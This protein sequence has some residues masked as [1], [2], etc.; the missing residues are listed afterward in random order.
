MTRES[1]VAELLELEFQPP[2]TAPACGFGLAAAG[3]VPCASAYTWGGE[4]TLCSHPHLRPQIP[5]GVRTSLASQVTGLT[6]ALSGKVFTLDPLLQR[7]LRWERPRSDAQAE[8]G[9][10]GHTHINTC[11]NTCAHRAT[12]RLQAV[13]PGD[14][15][16][17]DLAGCG[18]WELQVLKAGTGAPLLGTGT[19]PHPSPAVERWLCPSPPAFLVMCDDGEGCFQTPV[20]LRAHISCEQPLFPIREMKTREEVRGEDS[21]AQPRAYS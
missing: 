12:S 13:Q 8:S 5:L 9:Q 11:M 16:L 10:S 17:V 18:V 20:G 15:P 19:P 2:H 3:K 21:A 1:G 7:W 4:G 14:W 6:E